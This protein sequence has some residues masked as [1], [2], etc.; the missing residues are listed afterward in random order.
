MLNMIGYII[1]QDPSPTMVVYPSEKLAE[2]ISENRLQPMLKASP[3]LSE[4]FREYQSQK[5]ELQFSGMYLSLVGSN[6]P[7]ALA[8][9]AIK[10]LMLDEVDKYPSNTKKEADP[11]AL[12]R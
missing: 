2:S 10:Y 9:K 8:S 11:I 1:Q 4:L 5:L 6:S 7:S 3:T 12:A